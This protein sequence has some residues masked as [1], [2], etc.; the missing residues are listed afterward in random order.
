M[1][2]TERVLNLYKQGKIS[3]ATM[4]KVAAFK[5]EIEDFLNGEFEKTAANMA[6]IIL[7]SS[8]AGPAFAAGHHLMGK[9][10][11][12]FEQAGAG[13]RDEQAFKRM[14]EFRPSLKNED[15]L[16]VRKY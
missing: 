3:D 15:P 13:P 8:L 1:S 14:M 7:L 4:V 5:K 11:S 2:N 10:I 12:K 16:L 6:K 9:A